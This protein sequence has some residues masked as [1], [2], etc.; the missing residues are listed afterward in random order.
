M[1]TM[2]QIIAEVLSKRRN[3]IPA[4]MDE[5]TMCGCCEDARAVINA[6]RTPTERMVRV[7]V[8][9]ALHASVHGEDGWPKYIIGKHQAM[10]SAAMG[11]GSE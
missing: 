7:G 1:T 9:Y 4:C 11:D 5:P 6:M 10:M 3:C 2:V 8:E